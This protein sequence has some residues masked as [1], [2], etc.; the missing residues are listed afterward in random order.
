MLNANDRCDK[1]SCGAQ[2]WSEVFVPLGDDEVGRLMFCAHHFRSL[3]PA[4]EEK[5]YEYK[6]YSDQIN[7]RPSVSASAG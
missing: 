5:G 4:L 3:K 1:G 6:D 7:E 2:A